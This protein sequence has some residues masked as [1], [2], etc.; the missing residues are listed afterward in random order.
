VKLFSGFVKALP[1]VAAAV[2]AFQSTAKAQISPL[3][4]LPGAAG[5]T[6]YGADLYVSFVS[7]E[8]ADK[9]YLYLMNPALFVTNTYDQTGATTNNLAA[10]NSILI[11][12]NVDEFYDFHITLADLASI[13][14][15]ASGTELIWGIYDSSYPTGG[16]WNYSGN[17]LRNTPPVGGE[18]E[19][20]VTCSNAYN[21]T[22]AMED[23]RT[24]DIP[25]T[26]NTIDYNDLVFSVTAAPEPASVALM[27]TGLIGLAGFG[28]AR[29]RRRS[30]E[31]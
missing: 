9:D 31:V 19:S 16:R 6:W 4:N 22:V 30:S 20:Y 8:A 14:I 13:G 26:G 25:A 29:R 27:A 7:K 17:P 18:T 2:V 23:R 24:T 10:G 11:G 21:C 28:V 12:N 5:M 15:T 1:V 3:P